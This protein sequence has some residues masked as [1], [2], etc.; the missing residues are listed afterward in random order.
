MLEN[1][2]LWI[3]L[4][5][6]DI[7]GLL[8]VSLLISA[9]VLAAYLIRQSPKYLR[10]YSFEKLDAKTVGIIDTLII[11]EG[12]IETE[13]GGKVVHMDFQIEYTFNTGHSEFNLNEM[14]L[15]NE[16]E[17]LQRMKLSTLKKGDSIVVRYESLNPNNS[18]IVIE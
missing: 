1:I 6:D 18:R 5:Q 14:I 3:E 15:R 17:L 10:E 2:Q 12:I 7:K 13:A 11:R 16:L 8:K 4:H 9:I